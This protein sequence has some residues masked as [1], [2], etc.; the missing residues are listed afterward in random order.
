MSFTDLTLDRPA[1]ED[2]FDALKGM[3]STGYK[4]DDPSHKLFVVKSIF[5]RNMVKE[6]VKRECNINFKIRHPNITRVH[7][8]FE[9]EDEVIL[10]MD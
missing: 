3:V 8:I 6:R 2:E 4:K 7:E 9:T 1:D 10:I 5:K